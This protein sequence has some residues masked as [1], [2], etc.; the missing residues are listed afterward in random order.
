MRVHIILS[1]LGY[2]YNM[3]DRAEH[4]IKTAENFHF[5]LNFVH[6]L[7]AQ[8]SH[9]RKL[10]VLDFGA[11]PTPAPISTFDMLQKDQEIV[12]AYDPAVATP[13]RNS[14]KV[15]G[16]E[17]QWTNQAPIGEFH[18]I[19]CNFSLHHIG[20]DLGTTIQGLMAYSP[21]IIGIADYDYT[22]STQEDF[23]QTFVSEGEQKEL[24]A[25]FGENW[26]SC[27]DYHRRLGVDDF[28]GA[29]QALGFNLVT[30]RNGAGIAKNK[31][32]LIGKA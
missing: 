12:V 30:S 21:E 29:L 25:L 31:F 2:N 26:Q 14:E 5:Q 8:T 6:A 27:F 1:K 10:R 15:F 22:G 7:Q 11:G 16:A 13:L 18:L 9:I 23:E 17:V 4:F 24:R 20:G 3:D 19:V 28:K 32:Y